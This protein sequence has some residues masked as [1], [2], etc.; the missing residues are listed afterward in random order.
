MRQFPN[1]PSNQDPNDNFDPN[2]VH[3]LKQYQPLPP[4]P[5]SDLEDRVMALIQQEKM[6][7]P[8]FAQRLW[9]IPTAVVT[10]IC[11]LW[12][13]SRWVQPSP[14]LAQTDTQS[15]ELAAFLVANWQTVTEPVPNSQPVSAPAHHWQLL[16]HPEMTGPLSLSYQP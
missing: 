13:S 5:S 6:T 16:T 10:G 9:V 11:L 3:F 15:Q 8:R 14:Q 4:K 12:G 2:F 7:S 1:K